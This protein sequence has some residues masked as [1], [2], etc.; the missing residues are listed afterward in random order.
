MYHIPIN[1]KIAPC[2]SMVSCLN[3]RFFR[4]WRAQKAVCRSNNGGTS[5]FSV[6]LVLSGNSLAHVWNVWGWSDHAAILSTWIGNKIILASDM[7]RDLHPCL[8][9]FHN[10]YRDITHI[11][12]KT[13]YPQ[14]CLFFTHVTLW[15]PKNAIECGIWLMYVTVTHP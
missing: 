11:F 12:K 13:S 9:F 8:V 14:I 3:N 10:W 2:L 5:T 6:H 4:Q 15:P 1:L 7:W